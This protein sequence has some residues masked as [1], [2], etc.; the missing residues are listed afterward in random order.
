METKLF[1]PVQIGPYT[2]AHR[3]V[4]VPL[5][6]M[7]SSAGMVPNLLMAEYYTQR[8]TPGGFLL[9]EATVVSPNGSGYYGS[10]GQF[11]DVQQK[12]WE[13][14]TDAVHAKGAILFNQLLHVGRESHV[15]LQPG[16]AQPVGPSEVPHEDKVYTPGGWATASPNRALRTEEIPLLVQAFADA[17]GY[18]DYPFYK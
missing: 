18:T 17:R 11:T 8:A 5:T 13:I 1:S 10:P 16:G 3:V 12:G 6:R 2:I 9:T 4:L 14:I 15:E 7:R